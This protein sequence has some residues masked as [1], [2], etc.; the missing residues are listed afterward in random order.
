MVWKTGPNSQ[1]GLANANPAIPDSVPGGMGAVTAGY[2]ATQIGQIAQFF[3]DTQGPA[4]LI[5]LPGVA[6]L[7]AGDIV[8]YDL[9]PGAQ[10]T[11]RL[12]NNVQNNTG[13]PV[14][15]AIGAPLAGQY[16]WFQISGTAIINGLAGLVAGACYASA[17]AGS[18]K[19]AADAGDQIMGA[20]ILTALGTPAAGKSYALLN[21]PSMQ[22]QII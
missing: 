11:T 15:V 8:Y 3:E 16:G 22:G 1:L 17:T 9:T 19:T 4:E 5:Y 14:A 20:Q 13:R 21:R 18:V 7:T 10:A 12:I 2:I 6:A